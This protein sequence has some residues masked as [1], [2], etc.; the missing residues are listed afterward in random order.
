M[1]KL[2]N[3]I[4]VFSVFS[5]TFYDIPE[6]DAS[7]LDTGQFPLTKMPSKCSKCHG[8]GYTGKDTQTFGFYICSCVRK[9]I[10]HDILKAHES[11]TIK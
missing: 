7:L 11:A 3:T 4:P 2:N 5:G 1:Q 6:D 9:V 8:R 10:N